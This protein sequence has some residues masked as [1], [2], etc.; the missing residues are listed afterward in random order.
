MSVVRTLAA[1][2]TLTTVLVAGMPAPAA[3][4]DDARLNITSW[5]LPAQK[6]SSAACV[7]FPVQAKVARASGYEVDTVMG[8]VMKG[9]TLIDQTFTDEY[10]KDSFDFCPAYGDTFGAY[11]FGPSKVMGGNYA[12]GD[13]VQASDSTRGTL[14]IR[15][16]SKVNLST[17]RSGSYVT[18]K[19]RVTRF[20]VGNM[21][22]TWVGWQGAPLNVQYRTSSGSW[23]TTKTF[24]SGSLG[25]YQVK[26]SSKSSRTWR[27]TT[28]FNADT[29]SSASNT[30]TR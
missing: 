12:T 11:T 24:T 7:S 17:S 13:Y 4:A 3:H 19:G 27:V 21:T 29:A 1:V 28:G 10:G 2:G 20:S 5:N 9:S 15:R 25:Y 8:N 18:L 16:A 6:V 14:Y 30:S 26:L 22:G 23:V